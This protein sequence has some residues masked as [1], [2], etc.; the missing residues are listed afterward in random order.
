[1]A[2]RNVLGLGPCIEDVTTK[3]NEKWDKAMARVLFS[4]PTVYRAQ[5]NNHLG[6]SC[7]K[8]MYSTSPVLLRHWQ[9][10]TACLSLWVQ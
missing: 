6:F 3:Y 5:I 9:F 4:T 10:A 7:A 2:L 1:M 8:T